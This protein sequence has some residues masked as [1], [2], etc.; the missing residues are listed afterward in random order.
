[1][2]LD[3]LKDG[4]PEM[5]LVGSGCVG[6]GMDM[7]NS[8]LSIGGTLGFSLETAT[9]TQ[10]MSMGNSYVLLETASSHMVLDLPDPTPYQG[11]IYHLLKVDP[12]N[13]A[14]VRLGAYAKNSSAN[15]YLSHS[16]L[17]APSLSVVSTGSNWVLGSSSSGVTPFPVNAEELLCYY[18]FDESSGSNIQDGGP[19][20]Q[21]AQLSNLDFATHGSTGK[22]GRALGGFSGTKNLALKSFDDMNGPMTI[23]AWAKTT[24]SGTWQTIVSTGSFRFIVDSSG[25]LRYDSSN[26]HT[27]VNAFPSDGTWHHV[28]LVVD[29]AQSHLYL[30]GVKDSSGGVGAVHSSTNIS[31]GSTEYYYSTQVA[32]PWQGSLDEIYVF[33]RAL[34]DQEI[35]SYVEMSK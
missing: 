29:G 17:G 8:T 33:K 21:H 3:V 30:D 7:P 5:V 18:S 25:P 34:S 9:N 24:V 19:R 15:L 12:A 2:R 28:A 16:Y 26:N 27:G 1:M 10:T 35:L 13:V 32:R 4:H 20:G 31:I 22:N 11:R 14:K 23:M 6:I